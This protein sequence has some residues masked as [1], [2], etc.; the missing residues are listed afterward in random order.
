MAGHNSTINNIAL[1]F[2]GVSGEHE[3]SLV[4]ARFLAEN[5]IKNHFQIYYLYIDK[6]GAWHHV[7]AIPENPDG[8]EKNPVILNLADGSVTDRKKFSFTPDFFFPAIHGTNGEDGTLQGLLEILHKPYAGNGV[9]TSAACM[10]KGHFHHLMQ[11]HGIPQV[12][13]VILDKNNQNKYILP[14]FPF[15]WFVKPANMGSS[16]GVHK[17]KNLEEALPKIMDAFQYDDHLVIERGHRVREIEFSILGNYPEYRISIA[18][19]II[20]SHEFYSYE[21]KYKDPDGAKLVVPAPLPP[22]ILRQMQDTA[23]DA[24]RAVRGDGFARV[25]FF[26]DADTGDYYLNEINTI[27]GF[28]PISMFPQ[29]WNHSGLKPGDL[30]KDIILLGIQK[31]KQKKNLKTDFQN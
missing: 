14:D 11:S 31:W 7:T 21:A 12:S 1:I 22:E 6:S 16:V 10:D 23:R 26:I 27:P 3:V 8:A 9:F 4:S 29:L 18:G 28:T 25:D 15:P 24:F 2:G 30:V 17:I 13:Y 20:P 5:I 19:E